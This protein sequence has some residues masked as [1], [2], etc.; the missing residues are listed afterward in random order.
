MNKPFSIGRSESA[1]AAGAREARPDGDSSNWE[2][3]AYQEA[4]NQLASFFE[5][6]HD[7]LC[8]VGE[9]GRFVRV[10]SSFESVLGYSP[11]E[12][13]V[14]HFSEIVHEEDV[15]KSHE[16]F[17]RISSSHDLVNF[18]NRIRSSDGE[19][20]HIEWNANISGGLI[21]AMGR[22]ITSHLQSEIDLSWARQ[23]AEA[24][25]QAKSQFIAN[26]SHEIRTPM[27]GVMGAM[28]ILSRSKLDPRQARFVAIARQSAEQLLGLVN[29]ILDLSKIE[30]GKLDLEAKDFDLH[31]AIF[32]AAELFSDNAAAKGLELIVAVSPGVPRRV[33]G[34]PTR[35]RQVLVNLIGNAVKFTKKGEVSV[36][37]AVSRVNANEATVKIEV[38]DTGIGI[39]EQALARLFKPFSQADSSTTREY[40][41]TGLG[42]CIVK[43]IVEKMGGEVGVTSAPGEGSTFWFDAKLSLPR[44]K[45]GSEGKPTPAPLPGL[46]V[47]VVSNHPDTLEIAGFYLSAWRMNPLSASSVLEG[48]AALREAARDNKPFDFAIIDWALGEEEALAFARAVRANPGCEGTKQ[49]FLAPMSMSLGSHEKA[50][51]AGYAGFTGKPVRPSSL[52]DIMVGLL[53]ADGDLGRLVP[54]AAVSGGASPGAKFHARVLLVEDNLV[55]AEIANVFLTELGCETVHAGDGRAALSACCD[56]RFDAVFMDCQMPFMDGFAATRAIRKMEA[57]ENRPRTPII[58]LTANVFEKDRQ[59]CLAAGMDDFLS[60]PFTD[61]QLAA[62]LERAL[63]GAYRGPKNT[64]VHGVAAD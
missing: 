63:S 56:N 17:S 62:V 52:Y 50:I 61:E 19:Y 34:D 28:D 48:E 7:L 1:S 29:D 37:A 13:K 43:Q 45:A 53:A 4:T 60:K 11:A 10:S 30:S 5:L 40:G 21:F 55:N 41:G 15:I 47:L 57:Q 24:A 23:G 20:R 46:R 58:A 33:T 3:A 6:S 22:D 59:E 54:A 64:P 32:D 36:R 14:K 2:L 44:D 49:I 27:N 26:M 35:L 38:R 9:D 16:A 18:V 12:V 31:D 8:I 51:E 39:D 42:L 25:N